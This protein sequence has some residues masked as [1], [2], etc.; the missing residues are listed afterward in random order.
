[1]GNTVTV[2]E[3]AGACGNRSSSLG[4]RRQEDKKRKTSSFFAPRRAGV[5]RMSAVRFELTPPKRLRPE[6]SALDRS[7]THSIAVS[8]SKNLDVL[9]REQRLLRARPEQRSVSDTATVCA[10]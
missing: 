6:R 2:F 5:K 9:E 1:M 3:T 7:A 10:C 4:S 8:T